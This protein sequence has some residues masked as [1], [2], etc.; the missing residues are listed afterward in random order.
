MENEIISNV[1]KELAKA[2]KTYP[3]MESYHEAY[4]IALEEFDELWDEIKKYKRNNPTN[5]NQIKKEAIQTIA[6][7]CRMLIEVSEMQ[8]NANQFCNLQALKEFCKLKNLEYASSKN[9]IDK[10]IGLCM[11][12]LSGLIHLK[13]TIEENDKK[14]ME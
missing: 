6:M 4:A 8:F 10:E 9:E 7:L 3:K 14:R 12:K 1:A 11:N 2:L 13:E 5:V